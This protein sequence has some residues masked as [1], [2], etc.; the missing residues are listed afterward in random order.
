M[1]TLAPLPWGRLSLRG[2]FQTSSRSTRKSTKSPI[3]SRINRKRRVIVG[4]ESFDHPEELPGPIRERYPS[5]TPFVLHGCIRA[6]GER[7][8]PSQA[9]LFTKETPG[10]VGVTKPCRV[11]RR[12][13]LIRHDFRIY[14]HSNLVASGAIETQCT[15]GCA[16]RGSSVRARARAL[17][18][19]MDLRRRSRPS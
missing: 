12:L 2:G 5:S 1:S 14:L 18:D 9:I 17:P 7:S 15:N 4:P 3:A 6:I 11:P 19:H 13:L 8:I 10:T 16:I